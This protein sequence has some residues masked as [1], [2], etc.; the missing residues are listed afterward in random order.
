MTAPR[1][2][3]APSTPTA[4][5]G[6]GAGAGAAGGAS[7]AGVG[8][9]AASTGRAHWHRRT[10]LL[11]LAYLAGV[12]VVGCVHPMLPQWRWLVIHLLLL[13]AVSNAIL[14]WS[15]HFTVAVLRA[16]APAG[17]RGEVLRL[18]VLNAGVLGVLTG[19][20]VDLPWL[21]VAGAALVFAAI[22]AHLWWLRAQVRAA[23]PARFAVTAHYYVAAGIALLTGVP[24]GAWMLVD[25]AARSRLLLF[26]AHVNLLGWVTF[27]VL[28][29]VLTLWP[30]ILRTR[31][32]DGAV[33]AARTALPTVAAGLALLA[34][35]ML[36][37]WPVLAVG[38]LAVFA[39][40]A[41]IVIRPAVLVGRGKPPASFAAWSLAAAGGWLLVALAVDA[42]NLATA[43]SPDAA[44]DGFS[45]VLLPLLVGFVAQTL[46]GALSY[47]LPMALGGG[48]AKVRAAT[49]ALDRHWPQRVVMAN[50]ALAVFAL[51]TSAYVRITTSLL[52][53][54]AL[55][56]FLVPAV[57]LVLARR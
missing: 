7:G 26:H 36:A 15:A 8:A 50:A 49:A 25:D 21:G 3:T 14:I 9:G 27:T 29:T 53:L 17:R 30:T 28:G 18:A 24:A 5:A 34:V 10:G 4:S 43:G 13:G 33:T 32:P 23:L 55:V 45:G 51:P 11:P 57:R 44:A 19:G 46:V 2:P 37:W 20:A 42:V 47:L 6:A 1:T 12:V 41:L 39:V 35:G 54:A 16:P 40:G 31:I 22:C 48:P 38:G 52:V 56:Q